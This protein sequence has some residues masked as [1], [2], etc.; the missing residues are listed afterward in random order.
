MKN[1]Y[2]DMTKAMYTKGEEIKV[3]GEACYRKVMQTPERT[4]FFMS[5]R[6]NSLKEAENGFRE[7]Y[8]KYVR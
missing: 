2:W 5:G 6:Y 3:Y 7:Y 8:N 1:Y 4:H